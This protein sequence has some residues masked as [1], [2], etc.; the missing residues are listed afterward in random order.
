M[1]NIENKAIETYRKNIA[2]FD[3]YF[4]NI[5]N[6]ISSFQSE[7]SAGIHTERWTLEY[8]DDSYFDIY[9]TVNNRFFYNTDSIKDA[10]DQAK[11]ITF[12]DANSF[13]NLININLPS[14]TK[15]PENISNSGVSY[16]VP[17]YSYFNKYKKEKKVYKKIEKYIFVGTGL[18]LHITTIANRLKSKAYMIIEPNI[19]IFILSLFTTDYTILQENPKNLFFSIADN[20]E[21]FSNQFLDFYQKYSVLNYTFKFSTITTGYEYYYNKIGNIL[22]KQDPLMFPFSAILEVAKRDINSL[23]NHYNFISY[24]KEILKNHKVSIVSPGPSLDKSIDWLSKNQ[25]DVLI[26]A[27]AAS[28]K[29]LE[30]HSIKPDIITSMDS[31]EVILNQF[32]LQNRDFYKNSIFLCSSSTNKKVLELFDKQNIFMFETILNIAYKD[33]EP[34]VGGSIGEI[35]YALSLLLGGEEIYLFGTDL[36]VDQDSGATHISEHI[37]SQEKSLNK[38][39]LDS[40]DTIRYDDLVEVEGNFEQKVLTTR[41]WS[42]TREFYNY[43]TAKYKKDQRV[44]NTS[45]GVSF[46]EVAPIRCDEID[47]DKIDI[48]KVKLHNELISSFKNSSKTT[49]DINELEDMKDDIKKVEQIELLIKKYKKKSFKEYKVFNHT[50]L[51]LLIDTLTLIDRM[52]YKYLKN[53]LDQYILSTDKVINDFFSHNIEFKSNKKHIT[54]INQYWIMPFEKTIKEARGFM[55]EVIDG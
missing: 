20:D 50:R 17:L 31:S 18:G 2:Y 21:Q 32:D 46:D 51:G 36:A 27:Y 22:T 54:A 9:D 24:D 30:K 35:T 25:D 34:L 5:S 11:N 33:M 26:I 28:L 42:N 14:Q 23:S 3:Q 38:K 15:L 41:Q 4:E 8:K 10:V 49:L 29:K 40:V 47:I 6:K 19:E 52:N 44:F 55:Q 53:V 45:D 16:F 7:V 48:D 12:D 37:H 39:E 1:R 43:Y 13:D